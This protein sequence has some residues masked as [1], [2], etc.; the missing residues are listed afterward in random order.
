MTQIAMNNKI[1]NTTKISSYYVNFERKSNLFKQKLQHASANVIINRVKRLKNIK[2]NIQKMQFKFEKYVNKK[3]K[4]D[5]QLKEKNKVYLLTK[6]LT[7]KRSAKKL[8]HVKIKSFFIK[9]IKKSV[10]YELNLLRNI[11][12]Y[13]MFYINMLEPT[14]LNT[15]IQKNFHFEDSEEKYTVKRILN[16]KDQKYLIK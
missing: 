4:K 8:N 5:S 11:R 7:T 9:T 3:R 16:K 10:N 1:S 15:F 2:N 13:S 14:D 6:N 12:I